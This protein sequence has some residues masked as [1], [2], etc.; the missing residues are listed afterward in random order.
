MK[1]RLTLL[2]MFLVIVLAFI[3][4]TAWTGWGQLFFSVG[5]LVIF[6]SIFILPSFIAYTSWRKDRKTY[7]R[8]L[9]S[10][11]W[12]LFSLAFCF[13][14][15]AFIGTKSGNFVRH[16][17]W[18]IHRD[19]IEQ[20]A[21]TEITE[22]KY[23]DTSYYLPV[24]S[25]KLRRPIFVLVNPENGTRFV[26]FVHGRTNSSRDQGFIFQYDEDPKAE[27]V[28]KSQVWHFN[29]LSDK[30]FSYSGFY[31]AKHPEISKII[32]R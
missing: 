28:L 30:W 32:K 1:T 14:T 4:L 8:L 18:I 19:K 9:L 13:I 2:F 22:N 26:F 10:L 23:A 29:P 31:Y 7:W 20:A 16:Y 3:S 12:F 5:L 21:S 15:V 25:A 24:A 17:Y 11:F 6:P 27:E